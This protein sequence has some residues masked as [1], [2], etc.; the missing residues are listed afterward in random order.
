VNTSTV[1]VPTNQTAVPDFPP[2]PVPDCRD[3]ARDF[4]AGRNERTRRL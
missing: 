1:I 3:L 4:L 2:V